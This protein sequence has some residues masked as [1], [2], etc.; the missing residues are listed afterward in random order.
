MS[1]DTS[2]PKIEIT[3]TGPVAPE[4]E[5]ILDGV[6]A[7]MN[8]SLGG[9]L[10]IEQL[11][12]PQGQLAQSQSAVTRDKDDAIVELINNVNPETSSGV[13]QDAIGK[14][15]F[16]ER[17]AAIATVVTC[18]CT[19][20]PG[21]L[22][23]A[24]S[25]VQ[26]TNNTI[27]VSA[28]D[29]TIGAGSTVDIDFTADTTGPI[30]APVDSVNKIYQQIPGWDTVTNSTAGIVGRDVESR[31]D[32]EF[33]RKNSVAFNA[34]GSLPAI[35]ANVGQVSGV[36]DVYTT[37]NDEPTSITIGTVTLVSHSLYV[38]VSGGDSTEIAQK[39]WE[40]KGVGCSYN[41][42]TSV[43]IEDTENY[44]APFPEYTVKF[45]RPDSVRTIW[46]VNVID[47]LRN[48]ANYEQLVK[49]AIVDS[50]TGADGSLKARIGSV[51]YALNY[52]SPIEAAGEIQVSSITVGRFGG[53]L[54][55]SETIEIDEFPT[56]DEND[57]TVNLI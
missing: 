12:T 45:Q 52:L 14:I 25:K 44:T 51:I 55:E 9:N 29:A 2:V 38:C 5:E 1:F 42:D 35:R 36:L 4:P 57:I 11:S 34:T 23:P 24:F 31:A 49:D 33:R 6:L 19:G 13:M 50:F 3:D 16:L 39:I 7:D 20:V 10:N 8:A 32:F 48:P 47:T 56:I 46:Q 26:S 27:F 30:E 21:T 40:R 37:E 41:G 43:I 18:T 54:S 53:S 15:Y 28:S 17:L 22:I